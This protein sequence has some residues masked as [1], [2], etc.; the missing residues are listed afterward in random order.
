[1][2]IRVAVTDYQKM[3]PEE[4]GNLLKVIKH[5]KENLKDDM[6]EVEGHAIQRALFTIS[7]KLSVMIAKKLTNEEALYFKSKEGGRWFAKEF[8]QF[9]ITKNV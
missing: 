7:D 6:A 5:Q 3:F 2:K 4:Y 9:A 1:M 8:N